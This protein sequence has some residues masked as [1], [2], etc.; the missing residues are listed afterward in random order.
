MKTRFILFLFILSFFSMSNSWGAAIGFEYDTAG[1][2]TFRRSITIRSA[3]VKEILDEE[4]MEMDEQPQVFTDVLAQSTIHIYP[5]PTK[6]LLRVEITGYGEN[7]PVSLQVYDMNGR[8]LMQESNVVSSTTI[9][10]S[11]QPAGVYIL[12]LVSD[13][14]KNEWKIIK[15]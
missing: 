13:T 3:T 4:E 6:G 11:S 7:N 8:A 5:N 9:D 10:L 12:R 1:N 2:R 15:E 14:E